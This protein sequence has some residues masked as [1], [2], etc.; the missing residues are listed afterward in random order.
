MQRQSVPPLGYTP[1]DEELLAAMQAA[2]LAARDLYQAAIDAGAEDDVYVALRDNH[3]AYVDALSGLLG[4]TAM[5]RRDDTLYDEQ[6]TVFEATGTELATGAYGFESSLL[7]TNID[8]LGQLQGADGARRVA[9]IVMVEARHCAVL[10]DLS[11]SGDDFTALFE[12][13][14]EPFELA[15]E[16]APG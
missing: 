15:V 6:L 9:S 12:N 11:G 14:A 10:A 7:A 3:R 8:V 16:A 2:E 1:A 13:D 4:R 5:G